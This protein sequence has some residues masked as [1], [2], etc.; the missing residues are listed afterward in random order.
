MRNLRAI[1]VRLLGLLGYRRRDEEFE[2]EL[3]SH[4]EMHI[5]EKVRGGLSP[6]EARREVLMHLGGAEQTRQAYRERAT[7]PW[8]EHICTMCV[9]H[10]EAFAVTQSLR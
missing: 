8:L 2:Q 3:G 4:I 7:L 5:E 6:A 9:M 1:W 10:C